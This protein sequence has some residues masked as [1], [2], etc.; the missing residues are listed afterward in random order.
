[1]KDEATTHLA[2][3]I[4]DHWL[5]VKVS[6]LAPGCGGGPAYGVVTE[7]TDD[8]VVLDGGNVW[9]RLQ[10]LSTIARTS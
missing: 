5:N 1:M 3:A 10:S 6:I 2:C 4:R 7:V 9:I 8:W